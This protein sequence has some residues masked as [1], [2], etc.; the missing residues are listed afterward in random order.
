[1]NTKGFK[2]QIEIMLF[3]A[4]VQCHYDYACAM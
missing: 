2:W 3:L 1:M 4:I